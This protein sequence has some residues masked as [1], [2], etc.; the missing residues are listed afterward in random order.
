MSLELSSV[1]DLPD[2]AEKYTPL[3]WQARE[4]ERLVVFFLL[5]LCSAG[6][7]N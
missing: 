7:S 3:L 1:S 4:D 6:R 2:P 5:N